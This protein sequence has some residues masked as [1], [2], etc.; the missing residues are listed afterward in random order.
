MVETDQ[1]LA[2][3]IAA[4]A[5]ERLVSARRDL[6]ASGLDHWSVKDAGDA[7]AQQY[8]MGELRTA[9]P[10]DA[11]LSEEGIE[12]PRRFSGGRVWIID[13]LDG[14]KEFAEPG[15]QDWAVHVALWEQDRFLAGAVALPAVNLVLT[16]DPAPPMPAMTRDRPRLITSRN[17]APG[18]AV[19]VVSVRLLP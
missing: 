8:L 9:R 2:A 5:G 6:F 15:R 14:T 4:G 17:P 11:V 16:T 1:A 10:D 7:I 19:L 12:D 13:P 3:R 18:A